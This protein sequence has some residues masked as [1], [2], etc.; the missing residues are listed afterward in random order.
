MNNS[1]KIFML[2][3]YS[4]IHNLLYIFLELS[5]YPIR[6]LF[7]KTRLRNMGKSVYIEHGCDFRFHNKISIDDYTTINKNCKFFA[8]YFDES[9]KI[10]IGKN[11]AIGPNTHMFAATHGYN[12]KVLTDFGKSIVVKDYVWIGGNSTILPGVTIGE[13]AIVA[14]GSVV[15]KDVEE[16]TIVGGNPAKFIKKREIE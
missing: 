13:G 3:T 7:Y 10:E 16:Y 9:C 6:F 2:S 11:V 12:K 1:N 15:T 14:G 5:P 8:S 4:Y